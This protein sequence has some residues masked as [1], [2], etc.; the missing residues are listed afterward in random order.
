MVF[1]V[2]IGPGV[3]PYP[4]YPTVGDAMRRLA[5]PACVVVQFGGGTWRLA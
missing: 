4:L 1:I 2:P 3:C 5:P